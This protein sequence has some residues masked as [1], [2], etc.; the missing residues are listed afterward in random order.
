VRIDPTWLRVFVRDTAETD[1]RGQGGLIS[2]D[3]ARAIVELATI[4]ASIDGSEDPEES[5]VLDQLS[6]IIYELAEMPVE[7]RTVFPTGNKQRAHEVAR[8][9]TR[10]ATRDLAYTIAYLLTIADLSEHRSES[11]ILVALRGTLDIDERRA[12]DLARSAALAVT[13]R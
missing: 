3:D 2:R 6:Q 13:P 5:E 1:Y 9:I 4:V 12:N 8:T 7:D 10:R 11:Q